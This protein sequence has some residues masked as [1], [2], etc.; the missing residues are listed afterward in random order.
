MLAYPRSDRLGGQEWQ[1]MTTVRFLLRAMQTQLQQWQSERKALKQQLQQL[2][3]Q[4]DEAQT[5]LEE[6]A[7]SLCNRNGEMA[8]LKSQLKDAHVSHATAR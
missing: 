1:L 6:T 2:R 4:S 3:S 8:L 7:W 5:R